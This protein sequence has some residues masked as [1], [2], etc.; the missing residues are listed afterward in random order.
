LKNMSSVQGVSLKL[1]Q[2]MQCSQIYS[3]I[4]N[5][6]RYGDN[7]IPIKKNSKRNILNWKNSNRPGTGNHVFFLDD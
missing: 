5:P 2:L 6:G 1:P 7:V 3:V 4:T